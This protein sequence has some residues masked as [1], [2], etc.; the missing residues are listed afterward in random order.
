MHFY[1]FCA[2]YD[3]FSIRRFD[4]FEFVLF[5]QTIFGTCIISVFLVNNFRLPLCQLKCYLL[6]VDWCILNI[7]IA[8]FHS[9]AFPIFFCTYPIRGVFQYFQFC[10]N[11]SV[12]CD[13]I[14]R[15]IFFLSEQFCY[16]DKKTLCI[17]KEVKL[18]MKKALFLKCMR[19]M[20]NGHTQILYAP[21]HERFFLCHSFPYRSLY[22]IGF[23]YSRCLA[24]CFDRMLLG[25]RFYFSWCISFMPILTS[26]VEWIERVVG[27]RWEK[28]VVVVAVAITLIQPFDIRFSFF[29]KIEKCRMR[30]A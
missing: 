19:M 7:I 8:A 22:F 2:D 16:C 26:L 3:R 10:L 1:Q 11:R 23:W 27:G 4:C 14:W 12:W 30:W 5:C 28:N 18:H 17:K 29:I 25:K 9:C 21:I 24:R 15:F 13:F 20:C 6:F